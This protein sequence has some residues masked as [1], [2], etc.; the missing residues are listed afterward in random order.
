[1]LKAKHLG[2]LGLLVVAGLLAFILFMFFTSLPDPKCAALLARPESDVHI[3]IPANC[4]QT[5]DVPSD[6]M[7]KYLENERNTRGLIF[8]KWIT[9]KTPNQTPTPGFAFER[10]P[11]W[12]P[13]YV[14][15]AYQFRRTVIILPYAQPVP[16]GSSVV[17]E[18]CFMPWRRYVSQIAGQCAGKFTVWK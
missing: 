18:V 8:K 17:A 10:D 12:L 5:T 11:R 13:S 2:L 7:V 6:D 3:S 4:I 14:P 15:R 16:K 1:M 9:C